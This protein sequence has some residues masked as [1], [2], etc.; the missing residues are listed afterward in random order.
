MTETDNIIMSK[1]SNQMSHSYSYQYLSNLF[2]KTSV[3]ELKKKAIH[4]LPNQSIESVLTSEA[5]KGGASLEQAFTGKLFEEQEVVPYIPSFLREEE[6]LS[7]TDRGS[8]YHKVMELLDFK[9]VLSVENRKE[10]E[11]QIT[12]QLDQFEAEGFLSQEWRNSIFLPKLLSFFESSLALRMCQAKER[13]MLYRE[14][15]FVLGIKASRLSKEFPEKEQVL[16]Q[17]IIDVFFEEDEKIIVADYKTDVVKR[18]E[19]LVERYRVQLDYY[20]EALTRLTRKEVTEKII[21]SFALGREI[22]IY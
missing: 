13:G 17:G 4:N 3:S 8:A 12:S 5:S 14:Q 2:V 20:G 6:T 11:A 7:G 15:P 19:E 16:I 21:Y 10:R 22:M 1:L 18:P 9:K